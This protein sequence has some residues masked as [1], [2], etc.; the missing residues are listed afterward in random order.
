[1]ILSV[2]EQVIDFLWATASGMAIAF[3]YDLFRIFRKAVKTGSIAV[4]VQ[5]IMFW[6]IACVIMFI[7]IYRCNDGELRG[8]LFLGAFLGAVLYVMLFSRAVMGS[9]LFII[10]ITSRAVRFLVFVVLYPFRLLVKLLAVPVRKAAKAA[11][12][13]LR[14]AR[15]GKKDKDLQADANEDLQQ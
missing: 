12:D 15:A 1:M 7:S 9:S 4:F 5:D 14:A 13:P 11:A 2:S 10:K 3:I 6:L 8:F